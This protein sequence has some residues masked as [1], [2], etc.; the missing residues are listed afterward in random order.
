MDSRLAHSVSWA[1]ASYS[2]DG[3]KLLWSNDNSV[4]QTEMK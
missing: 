3:T 4:P 1:G 2:D